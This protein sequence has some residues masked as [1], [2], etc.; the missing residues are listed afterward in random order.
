MP[1]IQLVILSSFVDEYGRN[2]VKLVGDSSLGKKGSDVKGM[3]LFSNGNIL[4]LL[5][6]E[7]F[8][9]AKLFHLLPSQTKQFQVIKMTEESIETMS[10]N[11]TCIGFGKQ[12]FK[13][14]VD[15]PHGIPVFKIC[16]AEIGRRISNSEGL[17]LSVD[18]AESHA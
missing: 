13:A 10:L 14:H 12:A 18:F 11:Q 6:G 2:L 17:V 16:P 1:L 4:Q 8:S 15:V 9:V 7:A 3:T 5:Q